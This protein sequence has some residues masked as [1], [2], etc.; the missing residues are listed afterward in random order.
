MLS[1]ELVYLLQSAGTPASQYM[2]DTA[3]RLALAEGYAALLPASGSPGRA[4]LSG[5][6]PQPAVAVQSGPVFFE[7]ITADNSI[8]VPPENRRQYGVEQPS[9]SSGLSLDLRDRAMELAAQRNFD[10]LV[11]GTVS[12]VRTEV[13]PPTKIGNV[14]R[15]SVRAEIHCAFQLLQVDNGNVVKAGAVSGFDAKTVA[16]GNN[17]NLNDYHLVSA[18]DKV[19][20]KAVHTAALKAAE[21]LTG[22]RLDQLNTD[23]EVDE[24]RTYYQDSPGKRLNP[25]QE[26]E[27]SSVD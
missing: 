8:L 24:E 7:E 9:P 21:T 12:M 5:F 16:V 20:Q 1:G 13:S 23:L 26:A 6:A 18:L 15:A 19:L 4:L 3:T 14:E 27:E 25:K 10:Y 17:L 2:P 11:V 22:K